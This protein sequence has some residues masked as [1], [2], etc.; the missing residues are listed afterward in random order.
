[1]ASEEYEHC[2][3]VWVQNFIVLSK[4]ITETKCFFKKNLYYS[5]K[6]C[7]YN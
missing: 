7:Y 4:P 3:V 1:V 6:W 2:L 5:M